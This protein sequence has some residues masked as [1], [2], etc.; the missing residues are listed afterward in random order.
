MRIPVL[1]PG[2]T[3][4]AD[5]RLVLLGHREHRAIGNIASLAHSIRDGGLRF[6][7]TIGPRY[8]LITG[9]RRLAAHEQLGLGYIRYRVIGTI[10]EALDVIAEED[11]DPRQSLP[12]TVAEAIF[13]DWQMRT[14]LEW[15]PRAGRRKAVGSTRGDRR[16]MLA[17]AAG[18]SPSQYTRACA[19]ILASQGFVRAMNHLHEL[20]DEMQIEAAREAA[21]M[22]DATEPGVVQPAYTHFRKALPAA[23]GPPEASAH[24]I[25]AAL[26]RLAGMTAAFSGLRLPPGATPE[27]LRRWDEEM[28]KHVMRPLSNFRKNQIRREINASTSEG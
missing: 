16:D 7:V 12:M 20:E 26:A 2:E 19:I 28:T 13:R 5:I 18:L 17:R 27:Q 6:P 11:A 10:A 15:W 3:G 8:G 22:L 1:T 9:R 4:A 23:S 21:K 14:E 24:D 25:D